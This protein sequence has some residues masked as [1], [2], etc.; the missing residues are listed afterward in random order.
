MI[1]SDKWMPL[2]IHSHQ[3]MS[4]RAHYLLLKFGDVVYGFL[5]IY[6]PNDRGARKGF[7]TQI[8]QQLPHADHWCMGG[9]FNMIEAPRDRVGG[10]NVVLAGS[11][12][13]S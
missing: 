8:V 1:L 12:L 2:L 11:E 6:A 7:Y 13:A 4:R 9:D 10:S 5:N 3:V